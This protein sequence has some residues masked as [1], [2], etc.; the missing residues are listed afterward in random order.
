MD[1]ASQPRRSA[2]Q[3]VGIASWLRDEE[4]SPILPNP[5]LSGRSARK[6]HPRLHDI[7]LSIYI[8]PMP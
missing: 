2:A 4:A 8:D 1:C 6:T 5:V 3:L 7:T